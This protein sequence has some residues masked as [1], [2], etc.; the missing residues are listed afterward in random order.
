MNHC[1]PWLGVLTSSVVALATVVLVFVGG[2][3]VGTLILAM[4]VVSRIIMRRVARAV[5]APAAVR[6]V[7]A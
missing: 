7:V 2:A 3:V 5:T 6:A 1:L 4:C